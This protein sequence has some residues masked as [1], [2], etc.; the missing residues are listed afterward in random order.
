MTQLSRELRESIIGDYILEA[1]VRLDSNPQSGRIGVWVKD[2]LS[3]GG[4]LSNGLIG[5]GR[6]ENQ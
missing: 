4:Y 2:G 1:E 6:A 3:F 5:D